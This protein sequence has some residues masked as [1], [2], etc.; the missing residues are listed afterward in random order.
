MGRNENQSGKRP[1]TGFTLVELLVVIA[2]IGILIALLL[3]AIQAAREAARR[4]QCTNHLSQLIVAVQNYHSAFTVYPPGTIE[5][6]GP[7]QNH[8]QGYH[9]SWFVQL[10]PYL[11]QQ[12]AYR[13]IDR[14]VGVYHPKNAAVR[15]LTISG[16]I[17]P[18]Q[19]SNT[20]GYS[21]YAAVHHD[22]EAPIDADNH[23]V[24]FRNSRVSYDD[25]TDG[26]A[27][28]LFLGE[29]TVESGDLGWMSGTRATLRN[30]GTSLNLTGLVNG[31]IQIAT[32]P[33][34]VDESLLPEGERTGAKYSPLGSFPGSSYSGPPNAALGPVP[35]QPPAAPA[36]PGPV[37]PVGGFGSS[38]IGGCQFA[39]G[40]GHVK[41]LGDSITAQ[42]LQQ[43]GHRADGKLL[44]ATDY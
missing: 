4:A 27:F 12:N 1:K 23:G 33:L 39:F 5:A 6:Q 20:S 43:L 2:I 14:S 22:V 28:T 42:V 21:T 11:E 16:V 9:H 8:A 37:L 26:S 35:P 36:G 17:C 40:D 25:V 3:P 15:R 18:S 32:D 7:I 34:E 31:S 19:P 41:F 44:N 29:K 30:M 13:Q 24:F 38:H 10:L